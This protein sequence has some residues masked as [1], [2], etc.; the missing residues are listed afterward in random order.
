GRAR[1]RAGMTAAQ[2]LESPP[3]GCLLLFGTE[4]QADSA[5]GEAAL[6][7]LSGPGLVVAFTS[8][9][10]QALSTFAHVVLPLATFAENAGTYVNAEGRWQSFDAVVRAV[11]ESRP[12]WKILRVLG[13]RLGIEGF[14]YSTA[15]QVCDEVR[16]AAG[17]GLPD[18]CAAARAV[19]EQRSTSSATLAD[20]DIPMYQVDPLVRR[21]RSLQLAGVR[22]LAAST[23]PARRRA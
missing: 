6:S 9:L 10:D 11:A 16:Q 12:G 5:A 14:D 19:P 8:Y 22:D 18:N 7:A 3:A 4:V 23:I 1:S 17:S 15:S 21:A 20:L 2:M 13:N